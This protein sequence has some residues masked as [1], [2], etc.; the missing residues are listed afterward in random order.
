MHEFADILHRSRFLAKLQ[1]GQAGR[2]IEPLH[3]VGG[4]V[5]EALGG[6]PVA[7]L[8]FT[9]P[10]DLTECAQTL[11]RECDGHW[12]WLD[13]ERR[14][15]RVLA[16]GMTCDFVP[17]RAATLAQDLALRDFTI[18]AMALDIF[19]PLQV[20]AIIDPLGGRDDLA[21]RRLRIAGP[22]VL[23]D[24][25]LRILKG[26]RHAAELELDIEPTTQAAMQ[27][28]APGL[29]QVAPERLRCELWQIFTAPA[30]NRGLEGLY[31]SG[32]GHVIFGPSFR[33]ALPFVHTVQKRL[34]ELF[35]LLDCACPYTR[36]WLAEP[37]EQHL[38]RATLLTFHALLHA[39][40]A[41]LP[42]RLARNW[43]F[44]RLATARLA[45][46]GNLRGMLWNDLARLPHR[47]RAIAQ[48]ALQS[49]PD[50]V[51]LL[52]GIGLQADLP[53]LETAR[54]LI[55]FLALLGELDDV[56][57]V[58]NLVDGTWLADE[59]GLEGAMIGVAQSALK[60]AEIYGG[61]AD[62]DDARRFL[63]RE[64][65]KRD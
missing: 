8:D 25:P 7:D 19:A 6:R 37:V 23:H 3:L 10:H 53:P 62:I 33:V 20:S 18:N 21:R 28:A 42:L 57:Q 24:D 55:P 26:L 47:P 65:G 44:G 27:A 48:W 45:A 64:F 54:K 60:R 49:G 35:A 41:S 11:A 59:L 1:Q 58:P 39:V 17:W 56:R 2:R 15:S 13:Q 12:F 46:L 30:A 4:A 51:D 31:A 22:G 9:S 38:D 52:L 40:E 43:R 16:G 50:P 61:I 32:A 34:R 5:R 29:L 63:R 14:Q 36:G